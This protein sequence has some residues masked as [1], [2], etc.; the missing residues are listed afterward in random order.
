MRPSAAIHGGNCSISGLGDAAID[1]ALAASGTSEGEVVGRSADGSVVGDGGTTR[2]IGAEDRRAV[3]C[4][5]TIGGLA[6]AANEP[7]R[8]CPRGDGG[9]VAQRTGSAADVRERVKLDNAFTQGKIAGEGVQACQTDN[10]V[11][12]PPGARV[13]VDSQRIAA[14]TVADDTRDR[15]QTSR[16]ACHRNTAVSA[17]CDTAKQIEFCLGVSEEDAQGATGA[18]GAESHHAVLIDDEIGDGSA[19]GVVHIE[20]THRT[21]SQSE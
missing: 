18:A 9:A 11:G 12:L 15:E 19:R 6:D 1:D 5:G 14:A 21:S 3:L 10:S 2:S 20:L 8:A 13:V 16:I 4:D 17:Q 7:K